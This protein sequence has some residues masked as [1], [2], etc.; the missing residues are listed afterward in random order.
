MAKAKQAMRRKGRTKWRRLDHARIKNIIE[1]QSQ[2]APIDWVQTGAKPSIRSATAR[3]LY[4]MH[5]RLALYRALLTKEAGSTGTVDMKML[6]RLVRRANTTDLHRT[7]FEHLKSS[8][9]EG[10]FA[11]LSYGLSYR[12]LRIGDLV[13]LPAEFAGEIVQCVAI[14]R[15]ENNQQL[16]SLAREEHSTDL[17]NAERLAGVL[18]YAFKCDGRR[19]ADVRRYG[20][21]LKDARPEVNL[22]ARKGGPRR[23]KRVREVVLSRMPRLRKTENKKEHEFGVWDAACRGFSGGR[24]LTYA[25]LLKIASADTLGRTERRLRQREVRRLVTQVFSPVYTRCLT[26]GLIDTDPHRRK[27]QVSLLLATKA[28]LL[29]KR[30]I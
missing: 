27:L 11:A 19:L 25:T 7:V 15:H 21:V 16:M 5:F 23:V 30:P 22:S 29:G 4:R 2:G 8:G 18:W 28:Q 3:L 26:A 9:L 17:S 6:L 20:R 1:S 10:Q 12:D 13:S 24:A 14:W